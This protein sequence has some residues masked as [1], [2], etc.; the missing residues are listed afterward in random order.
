MAIIDIQAIPTH[1]L[2]E[3]KTTHPRTQIIYF[4]C[5]ITLKDGLRSTFKEITSNFRKIDIL[6][7]AAGIFNVI[8]V[9]R[10]YKVNVVC[11]CQRVVIVLN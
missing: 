7:N 10:T 2:D 4:Q 11:V 9:E 8:D 5:D 1:L 6:I 3:L